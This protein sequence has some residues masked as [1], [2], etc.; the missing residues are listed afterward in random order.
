MNIK[1]TILELYSNLP[2][3]IR[4]L[5]NNYSQVHDFYN[6]AQWWPKGRIENW[7][8]ERLKK[9]VTFAY[10]NTAG[11]RQLYDEANIKPSDIQT[12]GDVQLLPFTTYY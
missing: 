7:Q 8:L 1:S 3:S 12:L 2:P 6:E 5:G 11:Y 9:V 4:H 10:E